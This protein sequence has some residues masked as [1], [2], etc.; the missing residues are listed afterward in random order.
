MPAY[1]KNNSRRK[2]IRNTALAA[3]GFFIVPRYVLGKGYTAPSD[4]LNIAGIGVGGKAEV[5]LPYAFN[6]GSDNIVALCDVDDRQ[7][8]NGRKRWPKAPYYKD[9]RQM[10]EKENKNIDAVIIT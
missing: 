4:K 1:K 5:N 8:V 2:F 3:S 9:F 10:L 6:K 7:A